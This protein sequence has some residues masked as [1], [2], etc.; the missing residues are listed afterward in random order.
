MVFAVITLDFSG[1]RSERDTP[2]AF[3]LPPLAQHDD[4]TGATRC[5]TP[6]NQSIHRKFSP[7]LLFI[8][9]IHK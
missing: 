3:S 9:K 1:E 5:H 6:Q 7:I 2:D 8:T 4:I